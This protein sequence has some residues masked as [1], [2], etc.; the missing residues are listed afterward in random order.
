MSQ[1]S[2]PQDLLPS[3][4]K[5]VRLARKQGASG[6]E[7][8]YT[9]T[10]ER[11]IKAFGTKI[12]DQTESESRILSGRVFV[13][14]GASASFSINA[15]L[16]GRHPA[17]VEKAVVRARK[18]RANP[19]AG[20]IEHMD[21]SER[22]MGLN[23]P[24]YTQIDNESFQ[25]LL[26]INQVGEGNK[27]HLMEY[28][29]RKL[30]RFFVSSRD[31]YANSTSTFYKLC[32]ENTIPGTNTPLHH[33][34][35]G[36]AFSHVGSIPFGREMETRM[37]T[38]SNLCEAPSGPVNLVLPTRVMAW[39]IEALAPAFDSRYIDSDS[40]FLKRLP[41][42]ILGTRAIHI[43][44]DPAAVGGVRTRAFDDQGVPPMAV[45]IIREGKVGNAYFSVE[46][47]RKANVRP[48]G[49]FWMNQIRPSNL[50]LRP[51]NRSRTQ[52][53][54]EVPSSLE[55]D[56]LTGSLDL[57]TGMLNA[58]GPALVLEKGKPQGAVRSVTLNMPIQDLLG[59]VKE[60]A[61]N[62]LRYG[63]VDSATVVTHPLDVEI[64]P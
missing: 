8:L 4:N 50:V 17:S 64:T 46:A 11:R 37:A 14:N 25:D 19:Y 59:A 13:G 20:P 9:A 60:I 15:D 6:I 48:T 36:R 52:M 55:I 63:A 62:Q 22:G 49:H 33:L 53:L 3:L 18:A 57:K 7:L 40:V 28:T 56:H 51:G 29:D 1:E 61:S 44:D 26:A 27:A 30:Q 47:A 35:C 23:D 58:S 16:T 24:R 32:L 43:V 39:I 41:G 10:L 2:S 31:F 38:L 54:S 21:I 34:A 45:P 12:Q 42:G 5:L